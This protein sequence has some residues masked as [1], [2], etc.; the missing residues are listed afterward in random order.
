MP[1]VHAKPKFAETCSRR[2]VWGSRVPPL[3]VIP[4]K[5]GTHASFSNLDARTASGRDLKPF[6]FEEAG[7]VA[8]EAGGFGDEAAL[9]AGQAVDQ[10]QADIARG[11]DQH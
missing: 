7:E 9:Q 3:D 11:A 2:I 1:V 6:G 5:V 10:T 4:T 8:G